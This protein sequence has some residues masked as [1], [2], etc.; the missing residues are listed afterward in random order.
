MAPLFSFKPACCACTF[1]HWFR[2]LV[3][4]YTSESRYSPLDPPSSLVTRSQALAQRRRQWSQPT[5]SPNSPTSEV[6]SPTAIA[7]EI[8]PG[9]CCGHKSK[10]DESSRDLETWTVAEVVCLV[11]G[12]S[13]LAIG[14][15]LALG[16]WGAILVP[17]QLIQWNYSGLLGPGL[18]TTLVSHGFVFGP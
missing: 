15:S 13:C 9:L 1:H 5:N 6:S 18:F 14:I 17:N 8:S 10:R 3:V 12:F 16:L 11:E 7:A 4:G 2:P